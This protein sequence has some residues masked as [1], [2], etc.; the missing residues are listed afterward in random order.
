MDG[1]W[2]RK[3]RESQSSD[4]HEHGGRVYSSLEQHGYNLAKGQFP[5]DPVILAHR[6]KL[7]AMDG[8][9]DDDHMLYDG[10]HRV[11]AGADIEE[12][13]G[14][15]VWINVSNYDAQTERAN[16]HLQVNF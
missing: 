4:R 14:R 3:V 2:D 6:E 1:M 5:N 16:P 13:T 11:A 7:G 15:N 9:D 8:G 12:R 10:H